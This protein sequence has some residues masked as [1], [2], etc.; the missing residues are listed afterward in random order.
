MERRRK[1]S[2]ASWTG[3]HRHSMLQKLKMLVKYVHCVHSDSDSAMALARVLA[4]N[5][6]LSV[7]LPLPIPLTLPLTMLLTLLLPLLLLLVGY[8]TINLFRTEGRIL[9]LVL[10]QLKLKLNLYKYYK[11]SAVVLITTSNI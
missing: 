10:V 5:L 11:S 9:F 4:L 6:P 7:C 1:T 3:K 8:V 2:K